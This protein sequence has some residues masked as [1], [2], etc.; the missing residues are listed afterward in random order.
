V[1]GYSSIQAYVPYTMWQSLDA[2]KTLIRDIALR[3]YD[4]GLLA[5]NAVPFPI[6]VKHGSSDGTAS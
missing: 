4:H 3:S 6:H 2:K 5:E 1:S